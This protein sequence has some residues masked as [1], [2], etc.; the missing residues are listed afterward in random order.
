MATINY[1]NR[2]LECKIVYYGPGLCGKTTNL[3]TIHRM[4]PGDKRGEMSSVATQQDRTLFFD[5]LPMEI[6]KVRGFTVRLRLFTVPGQVYYNQSRKLVLQG[7]DG[8][9]FVADS[10]PDKRQE[11]KE[12]LQNLFDNLRDNRIESD[13]LPVIFQ[14][15]KRDLPGAIGLNELNADLNPKN[16]PYFEAVA[17]TGQGVFDTLKCVMTAVIE[18]FK[19]SLGEGEPPTGEPVAPAATVHAKPKPSVDHSPTHQPATTEKVSWWKRLFGKG[20]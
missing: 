15:N 10:Q 17:T 9:V 2:E 6:G 11:N 19:R 8:I 5:L 4:L 18:D 1:A 20:K 16:L 14:Y 3:Q 13:N 12:S 7:A